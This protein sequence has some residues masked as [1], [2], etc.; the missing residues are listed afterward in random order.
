VG[1]AEFVE[2][3]EVYAQSGDGGEL[4]VAAFEWKGMRGETVVSIC[5]VVAEGTKG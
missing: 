3:S 5:A 4:G 1:V 2:Y